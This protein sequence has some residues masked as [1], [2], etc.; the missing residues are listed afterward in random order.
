MKVW[1][2]F[3]NS[4]RN[5]SRD[6]FRSEHRSLMWFGH[7]S[8]Y[9]L[10]VAILAAIGIDG[11]GSPHGL[12]RWLGVIPW[13]TWLAVIFFAI[14]HHQH[15][16]CE[17]CAAQ[18]PADPQ[19]TSERWRPAFWFE[20]SKWRYA[21]SAVL[22]AF[23]AATWWVHGWPLWFYLANSALLAGIWVGYLAMWEHV[24][25]QPWC[26]WCHWGEGGDEEVSPET[27][28]PSASR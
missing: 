19:A 13:L 21:P 8:V 16:L 7:Y 20:H 18:L 5:L 3:R 1:E 23:V 6:T 27:P 25:L 22:I 2:Y 24:R 28:V 9:V 12:T 17:R 4:W 14:P 11:L 26:P 10:G 15:R